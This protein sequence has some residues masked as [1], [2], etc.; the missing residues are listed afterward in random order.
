MPYIQPSRRRRLDGEINN[1][2]GTL[3]AMK[4]TEGDYN[5]AISRIIGSYPF[6][7]YSAINGLVGIL[8]CAKLEFYRRVAAPYENGKAKAN[9]D[10][11]EFNWKARGKK[12]RAK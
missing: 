3:E 8:E 1:L 10:V 6:R 4:A 7:N 2:A 9:G 12:G 11:A 5:Y